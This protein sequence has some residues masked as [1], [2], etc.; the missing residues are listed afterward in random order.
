MN[1]RAI[2]NIFPAFADPIADLLTVRPI[3]SPKISV[4]DPFLFLNHHGPQIYPENNQGLPFGPHPHR[5]FQTVTFI[6]EGDIAHKDSAGN[7]SIIE[8]GGV[9]W[10]SA[11]K[12]IVHEEISSTDFKKRGGP[13]EILQLWV[14]LPAK[15]KF[16]VPY[17]KGLQRHQIP[18]VL[19]DSERVQVQII[20]GDFAGTLGPFQPSTDLAVLMF[21]LKKDG[22]TQIQIPK[23]RQIFFYVVRGSVQ[24][25]EV[26]VSETNLVEFAFTGQ[27]INLSAST[28]ALVLICHADPY[29]EPIVSSGPFVMNTAEEIRQA[30]EDY[31]AG[32]F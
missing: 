8:R 26:T 30:Y 9:Q 24:V 11:G 4:L 3:P 18:V 14:N 27:Q 15:D 5:G 22:T 20:A 25:N 23:R 32:R 28:D 10:M 7:E 21:D 29:G 13:L 12:G 19:T 6:I 31:R 16:S 17:Y 2:K 1:T